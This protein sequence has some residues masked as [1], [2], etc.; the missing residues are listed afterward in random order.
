M[1]ERTGFEKLTLLC[2]VIGAAIVV[3]GAGAVVGGDIATAK[4]QQ[5]AT[6]T[7]GAT[8]DEFT[9]E[10]AFI[11]CPPPA[12]E[13]ELVAPE[14]DPEEPVAPTETV[15]PAATETPSEPVH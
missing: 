15:P 9:G 10:F 8:F 7:C 5:A 3:F 6:K 1:S 2:I 14:P 11:E 4:L 12:S 13:P